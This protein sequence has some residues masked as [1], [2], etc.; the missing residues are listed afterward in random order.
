MRALALSLLLLTGCWV[1]SGDTRPAHVAA[2]VK[3]G[4]T[5]AQVIEIGG[6]P[7]TMKVEAERRVV[8]TYGGT[9]VRWGADG[10]VEAVEPGP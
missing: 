4:M 10:R 7:D 5:Q 3:S 9:R 6:E 2:T 8:W 1:R